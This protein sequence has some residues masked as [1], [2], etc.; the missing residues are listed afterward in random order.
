MSI[1]L[2]LFSSHAFLHVHVTS[3][4]RV[5]AH[6]HPNQDN[7]TDKTGAAK[8]SHSNIEFCYF[9]NVNALDKF[10]LPVLLKEINPYAEF[11]IRESGREVRIR[12][13]LSYDFS[14]RAPPLC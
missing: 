13:V 11:Q 1:S 8:H 9:Q 10:I 4:G 6:S 12:F 14:L 3:D 7:P 5:I 2:A